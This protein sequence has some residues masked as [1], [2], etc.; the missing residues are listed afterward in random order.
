[1]NVE[2]LYALIVIFS[3]LVVFGALGFWVAYRFWWPLAKR[4]GVV[5]L[6]R[7]ASRQVIFAGVEGGTAEVQ[8]QVKKCRL[9]FGAAYLGMLICLFPLLGLE[10]ILFLSA[11]FLVTFFVSRPFRLTEGTR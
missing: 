1:M 4:L 9:A 7:T 10:G 6:N 2:V 8:A 3:P 5:P 11:C